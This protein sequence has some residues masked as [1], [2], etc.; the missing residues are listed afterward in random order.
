MSSKIQL[1]SANTPNGIKVAAALEEMGLE[2][3]PHLVDFRKGEQF[4]PEFLAVNPNNKIPAITDPN[5][6]EGKP[7]NVFESGAI[8]LYLAE[9]SGKFLPTDPHMKWETIQWLFFQMAGVGPMFGQFGHFTVYAKDKCTDPYPAERYTTEVKRL[10]G[11]LEKRLEGREYLVGDEYTIADI[12][13]W[14][15][16]LCLVKFYKGGEKVQ[17]EEFYP[18]VHAWWNKCADRPASKVAITVTPL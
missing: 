14:P 10:L 9:K 6:P 4:K 2:Y 11:V 15:W 7:L 5:G 12:A 18:R 17:L 13:T 1:F 8:L 16:L 3:E